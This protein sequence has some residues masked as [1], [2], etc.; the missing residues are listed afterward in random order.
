M[1]SP[2]YSTGLP[3]FRLHGLELLPVPM[4]PDGMNLDALAGLLA[5]KRP[6]LLYTMPNFQNPTG[7]T[8]SQAH[9]ER[10][11]ALCE[12]H[13]LPI[14]EDGFEEEMKYFGKAVLPIKSMD[15]RGIVA[16]LGTLSKVATP[17]LRIGWLAAPRPLVDIGRSLQRFSCHSVNTLAQSAVER[18]LASGA[19]EAHLRR[20]HKIYRKRM[21]AMLDGLRAHLPKR[22]VSYTEPQ[23]GYTLWLRVSGAKPSEAAIHERLLAA[24]VRLSSGRFFHPRAPAEPHFRVCIACRTVEE[25]DEGC[26][27]IGRVLRAVVEG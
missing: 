2:G 3:L 4:R 17:G 12:Q 18:F 7:I 13:R 10:L 22:G 25:I 27:R 15:R 6:A 16:Y 14:L 1:E 23:G 5:E 26:R 21:Q 19:Y 9:R 24:G 20:I 11:L 8:T